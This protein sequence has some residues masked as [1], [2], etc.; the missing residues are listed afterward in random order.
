VGPQLGN[1]LD[2]QAAYTEG[3]LGVFARPGS[4]SG[5]QLGEVRAA[6]RLARSNAEMSV[7]KMADEPA[8]SRRGAPVDLATAR[9]VVT[10]GRRISAVLVNLQAHLPPEG[11]GQLP[12]VGQFADAMA[13]RLRTE[14]GALRHR[15]TPWRTGERVSAALGHL[16]LQPAAGAHAGPVGGDEVSLRSVHRQMATE[17]SKG[18]N[19][20][21]VS[22][23]LLLSETDELVDAVNSISEMLSR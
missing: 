14:A 18:A 4:V 19:G 21:T 23:P 1:L 7:Q 9:G 8:R 3:V 6:T 15:V 20:T 13:A 10:N 22:L 2:A 16:G 5:R 12:G 17:L 11:S